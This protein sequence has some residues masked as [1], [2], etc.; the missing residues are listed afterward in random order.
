M[1]TLKNSEPKSIPIICEFIEGKR[2]EKMEKDNIK[3]NRDL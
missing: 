3:L 1:L 2:K